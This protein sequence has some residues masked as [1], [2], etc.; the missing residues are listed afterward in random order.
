MAS[1]TKSKLSKNLILINF[2]FKIK[3]WLCC[4]KWPIEFVVSGS[5]LSKSPVLL[6][7]HTKVCNIWLSITEQWFCPQS[8]TVTV[9]LIY[10]VSC[11]TLL[12]VTIVWPDNFSTGEDSFFK[13]I[14]R[15]VLELLYNYNILPW[16]LVFQIPSQW[17][18][19][20]NI[21]CP[22]S[23]WT[24]HIHITFTFPTTIKLN[25]STHCISK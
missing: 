9:Y 12:N 3:S 18:Y 22:H 6:P 2:D 8:E 5:F 11:I 24:R 13:F 25:Y 19:V 10:Q 14:Y 23:I 16:L 15:V 17:L 20:Y 1:L 4:K 21:F 7:C